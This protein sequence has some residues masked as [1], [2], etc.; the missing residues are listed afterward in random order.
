M[1]E[2]SVCLCE[3]CLSFRIA[4]LQA[5]PPILEVRKEEE[6]WKR[7]LDISNFLVSGHSKGNIQDTETFFGLNMC[8]CKEHLS[9]M[10]PS[11][12][13]GMISF[14]LSLMKLASWV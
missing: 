14:K 1:L 6:W 2:H 9:F 11:F 8:I 13:R 7:I 4:P 5:L 3:Q 12:H 10:Y